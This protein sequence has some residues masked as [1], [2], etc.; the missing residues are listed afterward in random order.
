MNLELIITILLILLA[1]WT[2]G[3]IIA[4]SIVLYQTKDLKEALQSGIMWPV[5]LYWIILTLI[6]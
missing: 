4:F 5:G 3:T 1:I 2:A 6:N